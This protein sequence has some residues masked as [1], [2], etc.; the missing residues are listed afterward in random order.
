MF[1][2]FWTE[3]SERPRQTVQTKTRLLL[4]LQ[5][6]SDQSLHCLQ[7]PLYLWLQSKLHPPC[8]TFMLITSSFQVSQSS[9]P[10]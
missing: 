4:V 3:T 2:G 1:L 7:F 9:G 5:E 8:S 6:Q 10:F